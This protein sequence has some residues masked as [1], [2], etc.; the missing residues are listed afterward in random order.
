MKIK[1]LI[2]AFTFGFFLFLDSKTIAKDSARFSL[3]IGVFNYMEDGSPPHND[4]SGMINLEIHSGKKMFNLIK[5]FAGFLGT[6]ENAYYAY[7]GFGIDGYYGQKKNFI[8]TPSLACGYYKDG[9]EIKAG[10]PLE[11]YIGIDIF[12]RFKNNARV[13][14]GI[15][16]ISNADSG[17]KNP[18]S[19]T[20]VLKYQIPIG[21]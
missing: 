9:N 8:M 3:G 20:L 1:F 4:Q 10:N 21:K 5:P 15:F 17:K 7:G 16:H 18:G 13:G 14:V 11:F 6:N 12:Y 19:E 2:S